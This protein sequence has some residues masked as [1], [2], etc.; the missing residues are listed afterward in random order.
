M[1]KKLYVD[2]STP[3]APCMPL[4]V[5]ITSNIAHRKIATQ[6]EKG[7]IDEGFVSVI[8]R[9]RNSDVLTNLDKKFSSLSTEGRNDV[10]KLVQEFAYLFPDA[11]K[12]TKLVMHVVDVGNASPCKQHPYRVNSQ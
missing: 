7:P 4:T 5:A 6:D 12:G 1:L 10:A 9:L 8:V 2:C 11:P 3:S